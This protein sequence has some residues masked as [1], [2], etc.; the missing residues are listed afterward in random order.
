MSISQVR[1]NAFGP[2]VLGNVQKPGATQASFTI[3]SWPG[4]TNEVWASTDLLNWSFLDSVTNVS[5]AD[6]FID[7]TAT[8]PKRFYQIR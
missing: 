4:Q 1:L 8:A 3:N 2:A 6:T 7:N 5:G